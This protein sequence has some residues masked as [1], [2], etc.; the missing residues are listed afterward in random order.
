MLGKKKIV[1]AR[2]FPEFTNFFWES[3]SITLI[4]DYSIN[5]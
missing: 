5:L 4:G 2:I 3:A 1:F